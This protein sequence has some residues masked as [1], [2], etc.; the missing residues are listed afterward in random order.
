LKTSGSSKEVRGGRQSPKILHFIPLLCLGVLLLN[1]YRLYKVGYFFRDDFNNLYWVQQESFAHLI[2]HIVN[3]IPSYFRP[4]GMLCYWVLFRFF[5]L[6]PA[7]YH[8]LAWSLHAANTAFVYFILKRLTESRPGAA[9]GAM[10][11]ANQIVFADIYWNF[12]TIF[13]IVSAFFSFA[14]ILL[15]TSE[16]RG[17]LHVVVASLL[18]LLAVKGKEMAFTMPLIWLSYDLLLGSKMERRMVAHWL[19]PSGLTLL[20][21]LSYAAAVMTVLPILSPSH[22]SLPYYMSINGST[23][24]RGFGI[25][26]NMLLRTNFP[27][28]SWCIGFVALLLVFAFLRNRLAL[29]FQSYLFITFLPV[30]F[31]VNHRFAFYWYLPFLGVSGLAA[32]LAKTVAG[33]IETR[34]PHWLAEGGAYAV[35]ALLCWGSFLVQKEVTGPQRS[36]LRDHANENRAFVTGLRALPPPP[37]GET[38]FFDSHPSLFDERLLRTATRVAFRRTDLGAKLVTEFPPEARYRLRF[39]ESR[40]VQ[41]PQ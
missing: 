37:K 18:L 12:G 41:L 3:P 29:F 26:F 14:G 16:R 28:Q 8:W 17:W 25:Y 9:I 5:D 38:I 34:S 27:W 35:F 13:E 36:W 7:A 32:I 1:T 33:V 10:L 15:W 21:A 31:L 23:L 20:Y 22:S 30:I 24:A 6:N 19:L 11:F 4:T 2:G 40:L 39:E